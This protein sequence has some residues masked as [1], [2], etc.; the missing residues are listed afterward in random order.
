MCIRKTNT[1]TLW[2]VPHGRVSRLPTAKAD[3]GRITSCFSSLSTASQSEACLR[4]SRIGRSVRFLDT[5]VPR[6]PCDI[7]I[8]HILIARETVVTILN[9]A[10]EIRSQLS[11]MIVIGVVPIAPKDLYSFLA[12][13]MEELDKRKSLAVDTLRVLRYAHSY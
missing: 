8:Y 2:M 4:R 13:L 7:Y 12:L 6:V 5:C 1:L 9:L 10:P 11:A 3:T